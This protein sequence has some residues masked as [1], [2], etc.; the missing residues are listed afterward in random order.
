MTLDPG[1]RPSEGESYRVF[2]WKRQ[3]PFLP[4]YPCVAEET[5]RKSPPGKIKAHQGYFLLIWVTDGAF[6]HECGSAKVTLTPGAVLVIPPGPFAFRSENGGYHKF[7]IGMSGIECHHLMEDFCL[8]QFRAIPCGTELAGRIFRRIAGELHRADGGRMSL[9][10]GGCMELLAYL[11]E[12]LRQWQAGHQ[13][14][15][16]DRI[17]EKLERDFQ[18]PFSLKDLSAELGIPLST[19]HRVFFRRFR[20]SP[21][22]CQMKIRLRRAEE[23]LLSDL[24]FK[25]IADQTGFRNQF[26]F[27]NKI[28][29]EYGKSPSELRRCLRNAHENLI[30]KPEQKKK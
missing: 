28:R 23:L 30:I 13:K 25:E 27:S 9:M 8:N 6:L 21:K 7:L 16:A 2:L 10:L 12:S 14:T 29:Q 24:S 20:I 1:I 3:E 17:R 5:V 18:E 19:L 22:R 15:L 11:A 26:Y 4:L